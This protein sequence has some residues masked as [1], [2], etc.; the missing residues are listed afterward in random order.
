MIEKPPDK[1]YPFS[2]PIPFPAAIPDRMKKSTRRCLSALKGQFQDEPAFADMLEEDDRVIYEVY[3]IERPDVAG[4]L[5]MGISIIHPGKVGHEFYMT[6][7]HYHAFA[8]AA[9]TYIALQGEG[10][11]LMQTVNGEWQAEALTPGRVVYVPPGWAH[12]SICTSNQEDLVFFFIYPADAGHDY[13]AIEEQGFCKMVIDS[14]H[15]VEIIDNP[16][17]KKPE[18]V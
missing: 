8:G 3:E 14:E 10:I 15:G 5:L 1:D 13:G 9:E 17:W 12:R 7:G 2:F 6:K 4:E 11:L 18:S 16:R